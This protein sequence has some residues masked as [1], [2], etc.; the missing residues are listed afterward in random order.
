MWA[1]LENLAVVTTNSRFSFLD[2]LLNLFLG[3]CPFVRVVHVHVCYQQ[4]KLVLGAKPAS[5]EELD[6]KVEAAT[7]GVLPDEVANAL[8]VNLAR[9]CE[10]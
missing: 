10:R 9:L 6:V 4:I 8:Q 5:P 7:D 2:S 3:W 1:R